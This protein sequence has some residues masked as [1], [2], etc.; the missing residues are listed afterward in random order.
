MN[1]GMR[2]SAGLIPKNGIVLF[3][4]ILVLSACSRKESSE[5]NYLKLWY[6]KPATAWEEALP[7]GNGH[8]GAMVFGDPATELLQLNDDCFWA[9]S[10]YNNNNPEA[11][12]Y[13]RKIQE[14]IGMKKY[15]DAQDLVN[16]KFFTKTAQGV[17]Y[18][19]VG[20]LKLQ[21]RGHEKFSDYYRELDLNQ[22]LQT[23]TYRVGEVNFR[24]VIFASLSDDVVVIRVSADRPGRVSFVM[25][26]SS[27]QKGK[28]A[29]VNRNEL[30]LS[31]ENPAWKGIPGKLRVNMRARVIPSG[32]QVTAGDSTLTI[33]N[34]SSAV[35]LLSSA[36]NY[37]S[38]N[39]ISGD[40][41][42]KSIRTLEKAG[43][44][45]YRELFSSH[46]QKY[47]SQF[48]RVSIDLGTTEAV[49]LP[50]DRRVEM[51]S[52]TNDPQMVS[53]YYQF[54]RYLLISSSQ[55]GTQPA[56]LQGKWNK[57]K[58]PAWGSKYTININ[59]EMNYWPAEVSNLSELQRPLIGM[60][61]DLS[62]T[63]RLTASEMYDA[64][65]WVVHHNTDLWRIAGPVDGCWGMTAS[66]GAWLCLNIWEP[67]QFNGSEEYL[68]EI[69]PVLK[70]ACDYWLDV[71]WHEP[72][73]GYLLASPEA[74]PEN[75]PFDG[76]YDFACTT[77]SNQLIFTLFSNTATAARA[78]H[79]DGTFVKQLE[80]AIARLPPMKIGQYGQLQEWYE[81]WDRKEDHHR[82]VSH[83]LGLYPAN[84]I[85]PYRTP[86]LFEA[87]KNSL[88]YRGD[89][90]TGWSMGWK[91]CLWA[92]LL[93]GNRVYSLL[94]NQISP[95]GKQKGQSEQSGGTYPNLFD[96]HPPFQIDGNFG[97]TAGIAEMFIQSH[98]GAVFIL[99]AL[100]DH[101]KSGSIKGLKARGGFEI[102]MAWNDGEITRLHVK[103]A[104]GGNLRLRMYN[105]MKPEKFSLKLKTADGINPNPFF[106]LPDVKEPVI[107]EKA[108]LKGL[109]LK[110][111]SEFDLQTQAGK[112][113]KIF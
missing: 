42:T 103:S 29:V 67:Y 80:D 83:L 5:N 97:C 48:N 41:V 45:S 88:E 16:Q 47:R 11:K 110:A 64:H 17:P 13:F 61:K 105:D 19:P 98:D 66:C 31:A 37:V 95:V 71:L 74:S 32:G 73:I 70:G 53:L 87:V 14:L 49:T 39:D 38:Y 63:G 65:G 76:L 26:F 52:E 4:V 69:Y 55:P 62:I 44:R 91:T 51:F 43:N 78:L 96:A 100:P 104:L 40:E 20:D 94:K 111:F 59:T 28:I 77:I 36:T 106:A 2:R 92:R 75:T 93:D 57:D 99:P 9:G 102:D 27:P 34:A 35:I 10:P 90:S 86:E 58:E 79:V 46:L 56:N 1:N 84:L 89:I 81:D 7:V 82:H 113:Y 50:T 15:R 6:N 108:A 107:S 54:G 8:L 68:N 21:F 112:N 24:R 25:S 72:G 12:A 109:K 3:G 101:L 33:Q 22:A 60:M 23:T 85:S 30:S 18:Q